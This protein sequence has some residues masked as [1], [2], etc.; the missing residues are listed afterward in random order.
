LES[1]SAQGKWS[2]RLLRRVVQC[3]D[4]EAAVMIAAFILY[5]CVMAGYFSVRPVRETASTVLGSVRVSSLLGMTWIASMAIVPLYGWVVA[6]VRRSVS[7]PLIYGAVALMLA[8]IGILLLLEPQNLRALQVFFVSISVLNLFIMSVFW[9][10][11]LEIFT[12]EQ[13][14]RLFGVIAAAGTA[15]AL[16]G[17]LLTMLLVHQ[18][19]NPGVL[20]VGAGFFVVAILCQRFL[21]RIWHQQGREQAEPVAR[22]VP[23]GGNPMLDGLRLLL[24]SPYLLGIA[25]YIILLASVTTFLYFEQLRVV[26]ETFPDIATRTRVFGILDFIVQSCTLLLQLFLTGRIATRIGVIAL[27]VIV[28]L[29][30]VF[31]FLGLALLGNF[32]MLAIVMLGRRI[33]EYAFVRP[34]REMVFSGIGTAD[35]YRVKHVI[36]VPVYRGGDFLAGKVQT[37]LAASGLSAAAVAVVGAAV[38]GLW[39]LNGW[40]LGRR[41]ETLGTAAGAEGGRDAPIAGG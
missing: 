1:G 6:H 8:L 13:T 19:G 37:G 36:D 14:R 25:S 20:F 7:L 21:L 15:G 40:W 3:D 4:Y 31:G 2:T 5:F 39:A 16:T 12:R 17:P 30:M 38:A 22:D 26:A 41:R 29:A 33:G 23:L 18:I 28:P 11:L 9:S 35:R 32:T 34:G 24:T 10:F 27:L